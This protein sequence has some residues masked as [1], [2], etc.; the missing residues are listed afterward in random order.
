MTPLR[1]FVG[2]DPSEAVAYHVL[3]HSILRR[4]SKAVSVI[5]LARSTLGLIHKRSRGPRD[6]TDFAVTRFLVPQLSG[7]EGL[8]VYM[9]CD[10]LCRTDIHKVLEYVRGDF[11][12]WVCKH[13][14]TPKGKVKFLGHE[15]HAYPR[16]NWSSFMVFNNRRCRALTPEFLETAPG[17]DLHGFAWLKDSEIG[18]LPQDWNWLVGEYRQNPVARVLHYTNGG[19]WHQGYTDCDHATEWVRELK[20]AVHPLEAQVVAETVVS[21]ATPA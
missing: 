7:Y 11:A 8:S 14:Y 10:M 6:S 20:D 4:A 5:P 3:A 2:Y 15:Q 16:K 18:E 21:G 17:L 1:V 12:V 19:P 9:D 13:Q